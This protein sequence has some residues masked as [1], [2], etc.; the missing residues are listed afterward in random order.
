MSDLVIRGPVWVLDTPTNRAAAESIWATGQYSN[1][2]DAVT[3]FRSTSDAS[4]EDSLIWELDTIDLHHGFHSA[5]PPYTV[6]EVIGTGDNERIR[7]ELS[8]YGF[9][10]FKSTAEGLHAV[11]PLPIA[12]E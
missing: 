3:V 10:E 2:L 1:H 11:R 5:D 9:I 8:R 6:I 4:P 7:N 12:A